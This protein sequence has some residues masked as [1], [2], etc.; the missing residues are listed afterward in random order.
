MSHTEPAIK[1]AIIA[2]SAAHE[3]YQANDIEKIDGPDLALQQ[4]NKSIAHLNRQLS[5]PSRRNSDVAL[6]C[7]LLF[8]C[9]ES[10][11]SNQESALLHFANGVKILKARKFSVADENSGSVP[12]LDSHTDEE[13]IVEL[14]NRL[15]D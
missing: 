4:Y 6:I 15:D 5:N 3:R 2:L 14:F 8:V 12:Y 11:R 13:D 9:Y 10:V 1:H 7:C